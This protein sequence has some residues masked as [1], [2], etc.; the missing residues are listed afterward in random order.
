MGF[1]GPGMESLLVSERS[2][3]EWIALDPLGDQAL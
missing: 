1:P 2:L 3:L